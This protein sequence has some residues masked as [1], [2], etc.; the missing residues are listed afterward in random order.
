MANATDV[1]FMSLLNHDGTKLNFLLRRYFQDNFI[2]F[3]FINTRVM[4]VDAAT[5][6]YMGIYIYDMARLPY[7]GAMW[8]RDIGVSPVGFG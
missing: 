3:K 5:E 8:H 4:R 6:C 7:M 1:N 2:K